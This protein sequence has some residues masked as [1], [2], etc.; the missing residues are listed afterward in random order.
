LQGSNYIAVKLY[1]M[2][3][4][5]TAEAG[6]L[7]GIGAQRVRQLI[8][9]GRLPAEKAGRDWLIDPRALG[10]VKKR[11]PGRPRKS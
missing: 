1:R 8:L 9:G 7:L 11:K 4:L 3:L 5:T 6:K 10:P 2:R